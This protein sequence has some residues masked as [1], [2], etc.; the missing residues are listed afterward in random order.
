MNKKTTV[1][2]LLA[3]LCL[4]GCAASHTENKMISASFYPMYLISSEIAKS[5]GIEI[6]NTASPQTGCLHDYQLTT[7][8]IRQL[9]HSDVLIINGGGME[10]SFI[11]KA[12]EDAGIKI[13]DSSAHF[14][15]HEDEH[16]HESDEHTA[17]EHGH[18]HGENSHYWTSLSH[19]LLQAEAISHGLSEIYPEKEELFKKNLAEFE[20]K[21]H[22]L[23]HKY[24][25]SFYNNINV[26]SFHEAF[27]FFC[28][29]NNINIVKTFEID[30]NSTPSAKELAS[31]ADEAR[32][33]NVS[34][35]FAAD[36][37]G[38]TYARTVAEEIGVPLVILNP[39]TYENGET[40]NYFSAMDKNLSL[41][42]ELFENE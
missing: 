22:V 13:I 28:E 30:E 10:D 1:L 29:D 23:E 3:S 6:K 24:N 21:C 15:E 42:K 9:A 19:A 17:D 33:H 27:Q 38:K 5:S 35:I 26:I 34:A 32:R 20:E 12:S 25:F 31:A 41:I 37:S 14:E 39:L 2:A 40:E 8:N 18:D 36:D 16:H 4:S 7:G 11:E